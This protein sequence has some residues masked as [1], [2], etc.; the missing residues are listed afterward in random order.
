MLSFG[1]TFLWKLPGTSLPPQQWS[2]TDLCGVS[3][4]VATCGTFPI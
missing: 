2:C 4:K 3:W 1:E